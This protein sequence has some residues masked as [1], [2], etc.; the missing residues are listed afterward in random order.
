MDYLAISI[1]T[2]VCLLFFF[3]T[4]R[5]EPRSLTL[6]F[7]FILLLAGLALLGLALAIGFSGSLLSRVILIIGILFILLLML[8]PITMLV[9]LL[10]SGIRLVR[11]EGFGFTHLLSLGLGIDEGESALLQGYHRFATRRR[12]NP[13]RHN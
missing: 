12:K 11:R 7:S 4:Y 5:N 8:F 3:L 1:F 2:I 6:G 9:G 13:H 10:G